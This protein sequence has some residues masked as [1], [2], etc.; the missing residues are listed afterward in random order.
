[1]TD[2]RF[3]RLKSI[4]LAASELA[5]EERARYL[6]VAC[7]DDA[8]LR[9]EIESLL[10]HAQEVP[11][12][13]RTLGLGARLQ[14]TAGRNF[15][16]TPVSTD[17]E[18]I[19]PYRILERLGQGGMGVVYRAEQTE[20]LRREVALKLVAWGLDS[21][22]VAARFAAERQVLARM[23][24]PNIARV[25]DAGAD[26]H[27]RPFF[28][29]ELVRGVPI[30]EYCAAHNLSV[31]ERLRLMIA[32]CHAVQH[33]HQKGVIHRDLKPSNLL[34][35]T[36]DGEA[37]PKVIDFGIAKALDEGEAHRLTRDGQPLGTIHYMS[38]EQARGT[39]ADID[40]RSDVYALG[41][42]LYELLTGAL[43]C[44]AGD[45]SWLTAAR[46]VCEEPPR[47]F[48][49]VLPG[50]QRLDNDLE[51][52]V[53]K[54]LAKE[55]TDRY[56]TA[57]ALAEDLERFLASQPIL[58]RPPSTAY[59]LRKLI[60]RHRVPA[61][62]LAGIAVLIVA[63]GIVMSVL[64]V[65]ADAN[66]RR[67]LA[68]ESEAHQVSNFLT[69]LFE[70]SH[71]SEARGDSVTAREILDVGAARIEDELGDQPEVQSRL[72]HTMGVVYR[73]L[74][75]YAQSQQ[76]LESALAERRTLA[77]SGSLAE[78]AILT[79]LG[80]LH[81]T[82]GRIDEAAGAYDSA[83]TIRRSL[84][85]PDD[86][87][88]AVSLANL[89]WIRARQGEMPMAESLLS[90]SVAIFEMRGDS[91]SID[92]PAALNN[93]ARIRQAQRDFGAA[94]SLLTRSLALSEI[95]LPP[96]HPD[97][98]AV[99]SH[100]ANLHESLGRHELAAPLARRSLAIMEKVL[101]PDHP[102]LAVHLINMAS[103]DQQLGRHQQAEA[104]L[105][106]ALAIQERHLGPDHPNVA[107][108]LNNLGVLQFAMGRTAAAESSLTRSLAIRLQALG[109]DDAAVSA[110][111]ISLADFLTATGRFRP[112]E[113][114]YR[115]AIAIREAKYGPDDWRTALPVHNLGR[116][117]LTEGS[118][119][120]ARPWLERA[121]VIRERALGPTHTRIAESLEACA[122][123]HR[124]LGN[125][126][127]ANSLAARAESVRAEL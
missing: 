55:S 114:H 27:G 30:T 121:L 79:D 25:L 15:L 42:V 2:D 102:E 85:P 59:Q 24:H 66:L 112:A 96:D 105:L 89:G 9:A 78:A 51:T 97:V 31:R 8:E 45:D 111:L 46:A 57:A 64:F 32:V 68:A 125:A 16:A 124:R 77:G 62:L 11:S 52:V 88:V 95:C 104:S 72:M 91:S 103:I 115:R 17:P 34:V 80:N 100:L 107:A 93:L 70:I 118:L 127:A 22:R 94:E 3:A 74:G 38:P 28:V 126:A 109:P 7:G 90:T 10:A 54:A 110:T 29:M 50:G 5:P 40:V 53:R 116:M 67:A 84:L 117:F 19:G 120:Q 18:Q 61:F 56:A 113:T 39:S 44:A 76:F 86:P 41:V 106:R 75:L 58:A 122:E 71:P 14:Q 108:A 83:L 99:L 82:Q 23:E 119:V 4:L 123:L 49:E 37:I 12:V 47:P 33:A 6:N 92:W 20:P 98:A 81:N 63:F 65:R 43:P 26:E 21:G 13:I 36:T 60:A 69:G 48:A 1:M 87:L 73:G 101:G 35:A